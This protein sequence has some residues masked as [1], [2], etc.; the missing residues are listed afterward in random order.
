MAETTP[1]TAMSATDIEVIAAV[2]SMPVEKVRGVVWL[3]EKHLAECHPT[4][5][6]IVRDERD[7]AKRLTAEL[8]NIAHNMSH[9][10]SDG[11]FHIDEPTTGGARFCGPC[12]AWRVMNGSPDAY[13]GADRG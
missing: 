13:E 9:T 5:D 1:A 6:E 8:R 3:A 10:R 7:H 11:E 12:H 2:A 4:P